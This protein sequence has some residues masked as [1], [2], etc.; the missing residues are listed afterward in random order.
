MVGDMG[1]DCY[2]VISEQMINSLPNLTDREIRAVHNL[3]KLY[4]AKAFE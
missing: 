2:F 1:S 3:E 4:K